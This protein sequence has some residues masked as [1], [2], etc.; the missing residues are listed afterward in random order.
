MRST[1][2]GPLEDALR[3][4]ATSRGRQLGA[5]GPAGSRDARRADRAL[6]EAALDELE[7]NGYEP[8]SRG[9]EVVLTNCPFHALV[10][11]QRELVCGMNLDLLS[12]M[13]EALWRR[14][15]DGAPRTVG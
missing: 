5:H 9:G 10:E 2:D 8:R 1:A 12:G 7:D 11:E 4:T 13:A 15:P 6:L 14:R 3:E